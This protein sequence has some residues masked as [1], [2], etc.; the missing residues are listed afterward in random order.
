[1]IFRYF[2]AFLF[3]VTLFSCTKNN[4]ISPDIEVGPIFHPTNEITINGS[5]RLYSGNNYQDATISIE[6]QKIKPDKYGGFRFKGLV[7]NLDQ[8]VI[9]VEHPN[10]YTTSRVLVAE[11]NSEVYI[12]IPLKGINPDNSKVFLASEGKTIL[13]GFYKFNFHPNS[14]NDKNGK[15][16]AGNVIID[17][18]GLSA[19]I[20]DAPGDMRAKDKEGKIVFIEKVMG[21]FLKITDGNGNDLTLNKAYTCVYSVPGYISPMPQITPLWVFSDNDQFYKESGDVV[22]SNNELRVENESTGYVL[23]GRAWPAVLLRA[24][25][26][27]TSSLI[28]A[29]FQLDCNVGPFYDKKQFYLNS[30][31]NILFYVAAN[32]KLNLEL[33]YCDNLIQKFTL[34]PLNPNQV[35]NKS[36]M[37]FDASKVNL[38]NVTGR[39]V[40][41]NFL[42]LS[43]KVELNIDGVIYNAPLVNGKYTLSFP[44][45]GQGKPD[46]FSIF[47][48]NNRLLK[49]TDKFFYQSSTYESELVAV[50]DQPQTGTVTLTAQGESTTFTIPNDDVSVST[51][52]EAS[53]KKTVTIIQGTSADKSKSFYCT[54]QNNIVGWFPVYTFSFSVPGKNYFYT[55]ISGNG[56]SIVVNKYNQGKTIIEG[57]FDVKTSLNFSISNPDANSGINVHGVF[58]IKYP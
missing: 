52:Y 28:P 3:L 53:S 24:S 23:F 47:D 44:H 29:H 51:V 16:Y 15:L 42:P 49:T 31:G 34:G 13:S 6:G 48:E 32:S 38:T 41:C 1:M 58:N 14:F 17:I 56:G 7:S 54:Y 35:V 12:Y 10:S 22:N 33:S 25:F 50:C 46:K 2:Y 21:Y 45:C 19:G 36:I 8:V 30:Q 26:V 9:R 40:D 39:V 27:S 37:K 5:L 4:K 57:T 55:W 11:K 18:V 43:G 20:D